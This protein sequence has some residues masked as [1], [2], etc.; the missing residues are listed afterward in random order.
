MNQ[1]NKLKRGLY[2]S[3]NVAINT[4]NTLQLK[5]LIDFG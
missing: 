5:T 4:L 3:E 2:V 1:N